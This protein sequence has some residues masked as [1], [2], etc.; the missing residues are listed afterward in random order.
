MLIESSTGS[1]EVV[2][3]IDEF[4]KDSGQAESQLSPFQNKCPDELQ[5]KK[6]V[7]NLEFLESH[8]NELPSLPIAETSCFIH[9][10]ETFELQ[11]QET[12]SFLLD[13]QNEIPVFLKHSSPSP[14]KPPKTSIKHRD[15]L[16]KIKSHQP[17]RPGKFIEG[18]RKE[19]G[20]VVED[21]LSKHPA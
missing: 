3:T 10:S 19:L 12:N 7:E 4:M 17:A 14:I 21:F 15:E 8:S 6:P 13:H 18:H 20:K 11:P 1:P 9:R 5:Q 2:A 16:P